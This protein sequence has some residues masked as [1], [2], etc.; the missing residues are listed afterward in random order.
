VAL[1]FHRRADY[2]VAN[3]DG[4]KHEKSV[5]EPVY[6]IRQWPK[7][8]KWIAFNPEGDVM[9]Y[10]DTLGLAQLACDED[11]ARRSVMQARNEALGGSQRGASSHKLAIG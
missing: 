6:V 3:P 8:V 11:A 10:Y 5:G 4:S 2:Y 7:D 1:V 9:S